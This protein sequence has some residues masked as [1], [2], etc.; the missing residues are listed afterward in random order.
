[1]VNQKDRH[2]RYNAYQILTTYIEDAYYNCNMHKSAG[3]ALIMC[4]EV[5]LENEC[6]SSRQAFD[7]LSSALV[8]EML[9]MKQCFATWVI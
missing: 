7:N 4:P 1:M 9:A 3:M 2:V 8:A 6:V 5:G